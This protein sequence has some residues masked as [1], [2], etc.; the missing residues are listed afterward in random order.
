[1]QGSSIFF[2]S[3]NQRP[4]GPGDF[5]SWRLAASTASRPR[6]FRHVSDVF[7]IKAATI[8]RLGH[9]SRSRTP[10][11]ARPARSSKAVTA[12]SV[13][14]RE[15]CSVDAETRVCILKGWGPT[16]SLTGRVW[17]PVQEDG[18]LRQ[19]QWFLQCGPSGTPVIR[20]ILVL[21]SATHLEHRE[22][23]RLD[24]AGSPQHL[25]AQ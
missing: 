3:E 20:E 11:A 23:T 8:A 6:R 25:P 15:T 7:R 21:R 9:G 13:M 2:D 16:R 10:V 18:W 4:F 5:L 19:T 24:L 1:M 14:P 17:R 12:R 22:E